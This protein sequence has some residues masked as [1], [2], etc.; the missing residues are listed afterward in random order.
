MDSFEQL[1][2]MILQEGKHD[3]NIFKGIIVAGPPG[4]GKSYILNNYVNDGTLKVLDMDVA[5]EYLTK[6]LGFENQTGALDYR[7]LS[8]DQKKQLVDTRQ[9]AAKKTWGRTENPTQRH[10]G[11]AD[12][13]L[14]GGL[15]LIFSITGSSYSDTLKMT[16]Y[17]KNRGYDI[18]MVLVNAPLDVCLFANSKRSRKIPEDVLRDKHKKIQDNIPNFQKHFGKDFVVYD[19]IE[20]TGRSPGP[21]LADLGNKVRAFL[22]RPNTNKVYLQHKEQDFNTLT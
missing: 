9:Q 8:D 19:N 13:Y 18:M 20:R 22:A 11:F 12:L 14:K 4:A 3:K 17:F 1:V 5:T 2:D 21:K 15:G 10:K 7:K 16:N 6:R